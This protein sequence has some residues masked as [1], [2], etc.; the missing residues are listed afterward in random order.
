MLCFL[1]LRFFLVTKVGLRLRLVPTLDRLHDLGCYAKCR[2]D[3]AVCCLGDGR[4]ANFQY[5]ATARGQNNGSH[6]MSTELL[7]KTPPR[8][9]NPGLQ[10]PV[11]DRS[12]QMIGQHTKEDMGLHSVLQMMENGP[13]Q[14]RSLDV[15]E[16]ILH[17]REQNVS[18][19]N[20][21]R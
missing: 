7:A 19:P 8:G 6:M 2:V 16:G 17:A 10:E 12:Q 9:V 13:L 3:L 1:Q 5:P 15:A 21:F 18:P 11:L 14:Q 20:F 4:F